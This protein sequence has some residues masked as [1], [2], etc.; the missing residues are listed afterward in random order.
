MNAWGQ[1]NVYKIKLYNNHKTSV[2]SNNNLFRS[3]II[4]LAQLMLADIF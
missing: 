3:E 1:L 4:Y 2:S